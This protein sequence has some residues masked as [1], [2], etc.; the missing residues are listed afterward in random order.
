[1]ANLGQ[2]SK[3]LRGTIWETPFAPQQD[4][5]GQPGSGKDSGQMGTGL[6]RAAEAA[7]AGAIV[8]RRLALGR[9]Q[10]Q[11]TVVF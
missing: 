5:R 11:P 7:A 3:G 6:C 10:Q 8:L 9:G 2:H 1:M 4:F